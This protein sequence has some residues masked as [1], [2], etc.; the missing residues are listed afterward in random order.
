M[1]GTARIVV[2][3]IPHHL[4]QRDNRSSKKVLS[5][6]IGMNYSDRVWIFSTIDFA[7]GWFNRSAI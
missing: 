7:R 2:Q 6:R 3:G 1:P 5:S 4:I